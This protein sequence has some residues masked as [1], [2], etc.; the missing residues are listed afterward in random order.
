MKRGLFLVDLDKGKTYYIKV[1]LY[2]EAH[3]N[4][5]TALPQTVWGLLREYIISREIWSNMK[6]SVRNL[7]H[8]YD[9]HRRT[10]FSGN[11]TIGTCPKTDKVRIFFYFKKKILKI[12]KVSIHSTHKALYPPPLDYVQTVFMLSLDPLDVIS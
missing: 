10:T 5:Y 12:T 2:L 6:I 7:W 8:F 4:D 1:V 11:I 3:F 9:I